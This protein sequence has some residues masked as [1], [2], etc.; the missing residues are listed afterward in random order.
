MPKST[1]LV[2]RDYERP[3]DHCNKIKVIVVLSSDQIMLK[4]SLFV[5]D[6]KNEAV[7]KANFKA[8]FFYTLY[9]GRLYVCL[10]F[11]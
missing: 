8:A 10:V 5:L 2:L 1:T 7:L 6:L 11:C 4:I 3:G 9:Y